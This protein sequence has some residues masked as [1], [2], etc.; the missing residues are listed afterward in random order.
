M[1]GLWAAYGKVALTPVACVDFYL[2]GVKAMVPDKQTTCALQA[3]FCYELFLGVVCG[4]IYLPT[5]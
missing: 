3:G 1:L 5:S 2:A 4:G